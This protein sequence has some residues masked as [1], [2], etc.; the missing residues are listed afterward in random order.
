[1]GRLPDRLG[2][3]LRRAQVAVFQDLF[4][5]L[6]EFGITPAEYSALTLLAHNQAPRAG[7]IA[8]ALGIKPANF[9]RLQEKLEGRGLITRERAPDDGRAMAL[10]LTDAGRG[11]LAAL[12]QAIERHDV[13]AGASLGVDDRATLMRLLGVLAG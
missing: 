6:A 12:D 9:V 11:L 3:R 7:Q 2:Y 1:M 10:G 8:E 5:E 13:R 4:R